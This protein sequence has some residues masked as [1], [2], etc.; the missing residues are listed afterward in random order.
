MGALKCIAA[1]WAAVSALGCYHYAPAS[2]ETVPAG[3]RVRATL[4]P[5]AEAELREKAAIEAATLD[6]TLV[7]RGDRLLFD[8]RS[9]TAADGAGVRALY[10]RVDVAPQD[11]VRVEVR[12]LDAVRTGGLIAA[13]AGFT[14]FAVIQALGDPD[15]GSERP[16]N[17]TPPEHV[18]IWLP[19]IEIRF[20]P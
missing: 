13:L 15:P 1:A 12:R 17:G 3:T 5:A 10:Q 8:V 6:G 20:P 14:A 16:P 11:V 7:E 9:T 2:I 19:L 18:A 4:T